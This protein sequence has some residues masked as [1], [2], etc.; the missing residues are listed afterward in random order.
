MTRAIYFFFLICS[1]AVSASE[2][3]HGEKRNWAFGD[4]MNP[5]G[6][7]AFD[8]KRSFEPSF[9]MHKR[10]TPIGSAWRNWLDK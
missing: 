6:S 9:R 1:A 8:S 10:N 7:F 4:L 5:D 2:H 3:F